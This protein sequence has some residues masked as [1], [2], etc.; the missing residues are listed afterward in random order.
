MVNLAK[1][2]HLLLTPAEAQKVLSDQIRRLVKTEIRDISEALGYISAED[3]YSGEDIPP[4]DRSEVDGYAVNH[5]SM[6]GSE[7]DRPTQL[8]LVGE[9]EIGKPPTLEI[10]LGEA[11]YIATGAMLPRGADAVVMVEYTSR[12]KCR[13]KVYKSLSPGEN[14]AHAGSDFFAA[15]T[16]SRKG[17]EVVPETVALLASSGVKEIKVAKKLNIGIISTGDELVKPGKPLNLGQVYDSNA[18]YFKSVFESTG[19]AS[20]T[21]LGMLNDDEK[22]TRAFIEGAL[23]KYDILISSGSTSA[24]FHDLLYRVIEVLGGKMLFHGI[25]MKPGKPTFLASFPNTLFIGMP[26]FPL[27]AASVLRYIVI[28]SLKEAIFVNKQEEELVSPAFRINAERGKETVLPAIIGR[29]GRAYPIFGESGSISRLVYADGFMILPSTRNFYDRKDRIPFFR[30]SSGV[31]DLLFIGSN[32]PLLERV[33]FGTSRSPTIINAG[34]WG[35]VDAVRMGEADV[36]GIHLVKGNEYNTFLMNEELKN[37]SVLLRGFSRVQGFISRNGISSFKTVNENN[38]IFANRNKGSGTR[39]L[40]DSQI[41]KEL[42]KDFKR[43]KLRGYFWEA[44]SHA[45][46]AKAVKQ[47][48]ADTGISIEFYAII[49]GLEFHK[50]QEENYDILM[51]KDFYSSKIGKKFIYELKHIS[52]HSKEFPGYLFPENS[53]DIIG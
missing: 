10:R 29:S 22:Q 24:G 1:A 7:E 19:L 16:L 37:R 27:S 40:I 49:L 11:A 39:D 53:G 8:N 32:D 28:P 9:V 31:R 6:I 15:E 18:Y 3:A 45:A 5:Q 13:I 38:L 23:N 42:G 30:I 4:F 35:G 52:D 26:G 25:S 48:R 21:L 41:G 12:I 47:G 14:I 33:V 20:C 2:F 36:A 44:K 50:I 17:S 34:S 51:Q 43:D 46:V